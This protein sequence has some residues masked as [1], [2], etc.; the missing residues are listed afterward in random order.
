MKSEERNIIVFDLHD[1]LFERNYWQVIKALA[2]MDNKGKFIA[3]LLTPSFIIDALKMLLVTRVSEAYLIKLSQKHTRL[4][5]YLETIIDLTNVLLPMKEMFLLINLLKVKGYKI[6]IFSNIGS[7][8]YQKLYGSYQH[9]F[10]HF[11]GIHY[12]ESSNDW[13]AK[14]HE[15]A[16]RLFL[17]KYN[18]NPHQMIFIDD[19]PKN[20]IAAQQ[21]GITSIVFKSTRQLLQQ[22]T[23]LNVIS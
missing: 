11:D 19:K 13:L 21:H 15:D 1:V 18:I 5:P 9:F 8:T 3:L 16:Y 10:N 6:Y 22:L 20:V 2:Y 4:I 12:V 7:L 23:K 14:P 17:Q